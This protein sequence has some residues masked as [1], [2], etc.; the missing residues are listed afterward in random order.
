M[1]DNPPES[2]VADAHF[3]SAARVCVDYCMGVDRGDIL[4]G[5]VYDIFRAAKASRQLWRH[6]RTYAMPFTHVDVSP[7]P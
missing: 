7:F 3:D 6:M 1:V 5:P 4:M 2:V